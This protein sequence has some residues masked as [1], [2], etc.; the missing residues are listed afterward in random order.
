MAVVCMGSMYAGAIRAHAVRMEHGEPHSMCQGGGGRQLH[1]AGVQGHHCGGS[2]LER[3]TGVHLRHI[4]ALLV[5]QVLVLQVVLQVV[6]Q[7]AA[8]R[9]V[10]ARA[11]CD[12]TMTDADSKQYPRNAASGHARYQSTSSLMAGRSS[13]APHSSAKP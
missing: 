6:R 11:H 2:G 12:S 8:V 13:S 3:S 10:S 5:L 1:R 9:L 4:G 7:A